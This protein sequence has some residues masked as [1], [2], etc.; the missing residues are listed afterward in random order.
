LADVEE[1][2]VELPSWVP[3]GV[4]VTVPNAARAYDYALGG[5]HNFAVDREFVARAE[6]A[7]PGA[8]LVAHANR[9][10]LGRAVRWLVDAGVRQFLDIGSGIPTLGNVHEVAQEIAPATRVV[11]VDIDPVAV[12]HGQAILHDNPRATSIEGDLRRP[13]DILYHPEVLDLLD[14]AQPVAVLLMAVLHFISDED[15]PAGIVTQLHDGLVAG[16]YIAMSHAT[17]AAER[18]PE[19]EAVIRLYDRTPTPG[20]LRTP[21]QVADLLKGLAIVQPGVVP[22]TDW[23]PDP[24]DADDEPQEDEPQGTVLAAVARKS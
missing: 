11:Y 24:A 3:E 19:V 8:S 17:Q 2:E 16:S 22:V 14:F 5:Y 4:D 10:Y 20:H 21:T 12:A 15:D 23:R 7:M 9:A 18:G 6:A 13:A 1:H